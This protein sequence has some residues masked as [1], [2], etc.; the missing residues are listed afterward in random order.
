M[1]EWGRTRTCTSPFILRFLSTYYELPCDHN[2]NFSKIFFSKDIIKKPHPNVTRMW[3]KWKKNPTNT[4][5][6]KTNIFLH[7]ILLLNLPWLWMCLCTEMHTALYTWVI[8][9]GKSWTLLMYSWG[10]R[11]A[12]AFSCIFLW[13]VHIKGSKKFYLKISQIVDCLEQRRLRMNKRYKM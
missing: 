1:S 11:T 10:H 3:K 9:V 13:K 12:R 8:L 7:T 6:L 5:Y 2:L 4:L